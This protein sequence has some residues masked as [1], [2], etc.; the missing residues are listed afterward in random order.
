[1]RFSSWIHALQI[2]KEIE[3]VVLKS[4]W[5]MVEPTSA[6]LTLPWRHMGMVLSYI[7]ME[8]NGMRDNSLMVA[9]LEKEHSSIKMD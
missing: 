2:L 4:T 7:P 5:K 1:M 6:K 9:K 8:K 3:R